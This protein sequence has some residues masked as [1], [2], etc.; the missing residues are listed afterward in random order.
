[1]DN[2]KNDPKEIKFG[3]LVGNIGRLHATLADQYM[4]RIGLYRGQAIL[5]LIL[6]EENGLTHS[7]IAEKLEVSPPAATKVIKRMEA[8]K[9]VRRRPDSG[10]ERVSRVFLE[11]EGKAVIRQIKSALDQI[12]QVLLDSLA[13][14][15]QD[16]LIQLLLKIHESLLKAHT[17]GVV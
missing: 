11:Q 17:G 10:D 2:F 3:M 1:M 12:D 15:E 9:Y 16:Q 6:S 13:P 5:L 14:K 4:D 8:L 7:Q